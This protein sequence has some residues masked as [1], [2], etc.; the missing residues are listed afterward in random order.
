MTPE[1]LNELEALE[2]EDWI[3]DKERQVIK[4]LYAVLPENRKYAA[5]VSGEEL[6][7]QRGG[8][9][10]VLRLNGNDL[11][12]V[13]YEQAPHIVTFESLTADE[14]PRCLKKVFD[15]KKL[16]KIKRD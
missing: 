13:K 14:V 12:W 16:D 4:K 11:Y 1:E 6:I 2:T 5:R 9:Q 7:L 8:M 3:N 10:A 15:R